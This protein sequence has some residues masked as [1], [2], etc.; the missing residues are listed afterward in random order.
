MMKAKFGHVE[1]KHTQMHTM[2][3]V[4]DVIPILHFC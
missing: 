2:D 4:E 3:Y 1:E